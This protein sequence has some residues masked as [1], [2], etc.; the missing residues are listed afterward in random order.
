MTPR[1]ALAEVQGTGYRLALRPGGLRLTGE[2]EPPPGVL[3]LIREH[4]DG[5]LSLLET[6][7]RADAAHEA[8]L[9]A[10]RLVPFPAYLVPLVHPSIR[11]L[12]AVEKVRRKGAK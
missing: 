6:E 8:S 1:E 12:V 7:A 2:G 4:R 9:A 10:G 11:H 3:A 5:L